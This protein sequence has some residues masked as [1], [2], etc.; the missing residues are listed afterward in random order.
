MDA[1]CPYETPF[2]NDHAAKIVYI[3][4]SAFSASLSI[5]G[6]SLLLYILIRGGWSRFLQTR[7]RILFATSVIDVFSSIALGFSIL[8]TPQETDCSIGM[9][10]LST[11]AAQGFFLQ[12]GLA[13]PAYSAMLSLYYLLSIRYGMNPATIA[14]K[15]EP[16]MHAFALVPT[17]STAII[18]VTNKMFFSESAV[19]WIGDVCQSNGNCPSGNVW[20]KG[21]GIAIA[22]ICFVCICGFITILCLIAIS[23]TLRQRNLAMLRF[24]FRRE[25]NDRSSNRRLNDVEFAALESAKQAYLYATAMVVTWLGV[26]CDLISS[27]ISGETIPVPSWFHFH[28]IG[29]FLPLQGL[30]NF[31][32]YARPIVSKIRRDDEN[33]SYMAALRVVIVGENETSNSN[34]DPCTDTGGPSS[35]AQNM[36]RI[37]RDSLLLVPIEGS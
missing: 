21:Y 26:V 1:N 31:F 22:S 28:L 3:F 11:C 29:L 13:V 8:P 36:Q 32:A 34:S 18:G 10:N 7:N 30:W 20:G 35:D 15:Y 33:I 4:L 25:I 17:L 9:G 2:L 5:S 27:N 6:S 12:F 14:K 23:W 19:C 24:R 16:F 37:R